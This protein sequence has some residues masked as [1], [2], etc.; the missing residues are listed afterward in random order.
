[1]A[2]QQV[3]VNLTVSDQSGSLK[4]RNKEAKEL[5]ENLSKAAQSAEKAIRQTAAAK[6]QPQGEGA[7]YGRARGIAGATGAGARDFA[8]QAQGLGGLVR[9]YATYAANVFAVS[10]AFR[11]L[12]DAM[13]TE[14]M[15]RGLDQLGARSG[16]ALGGLAKLFS[17]VTGGAISTRE[18][19]ESTA[20]AMS[21]GMSAKQFLQLGE[22]AR[23]ASQALGLSMPDAVNRLVR[24]T[25]KLEPELLDE[26]GL[27]TKVGKA[28]EDYARS[29]GKT[30][31]SLTDLEK[32]QAFLNAVIKEG[33]DKFAAI[34][35]PTNPYDKLLSSLK[36]VAQTILEVVN[37][38]LTPLVELLSKSPTAL[39]GVIAGLG[40]MILRQA[41]PIFTSYREAMAKANKEMELMAAKKAETAKKSLEIARRA[42]EQEVLEER[43]KLTEIR[44]D[45]ID[46]QVSAL[47]Q[48]SKRGISKG[49][50]KVID[51]L[52]DITKIT[53]QE[54]DMLDRLG[55]KN[56]KVAAVYKELAAAIRLA[57]KAEKD[58]SEQQAGID[59]RVRAPAPFL[60]RADIAE[61][62]LEKARRQAASASLLQRVGATAQEVGPMAA[63]GQLITGIKTEKLGLLRGGITAI[64]G[65]ASIATTAITGLFTAVSSFLGY[66]GI[67]TVIFET[68]DSLL[69]KNSK[70]AEAFSQALDMSAES[71]KSA[72][73]TA[74][75]FANVLNPQN[76][77]ASGNALINTKDS[78][79]ALTTALYNVDKA[80][81]GWD[82]FIDGFKAITGSNLQAKFAD[83]VAK[84]VSA[85]IAVI[86]DPKLQEE[87]K[88][89]LK[90]L[91]N[92]GEVTEESVGKAIKS[93]DVSEVIQT[94]RKVSTVFEVIGAKAKKA[95]NDIT[96]LQDSFTELD[97][98]FSELSNQLIAKD[99]FSTFGRN[100]AKTGFE[101]E[102]VFQNPTSAAANLLDIM[103]DMSKLKLLSPD[104]Q[105]MLLANK[106]AMVKLSDQLN[107]INTQ[108]KKTEDDL[109]KVASSGMD[110]ITPEG[111]LQ[112]TRDTTAE[113]KFNAQLAQLKGQQQT[114]QTAMSALTKD[115][116]G[117][118][119]QSIEYGFKIM[120]VSYERAVREGTIAAQKG[121]LDFLPKTPGTIQM[122]TKLE[123]DKISL[124]IQEINQTERLITEL[125][126]L[127]LTEER[128]RV[129]EET[130]R[131]LSSR[132]LTSAQVDLLLQ[133]KSQKIGAI[134]ARE[135]AL[136]SPNVAKAIKSGQIAL[137]S[138]T[139][140]VSDRQRASMLK[141]QG[142]LDQQQLNIIK[143]KVE[144]TAALADQDKRGLQL[145]KDSVLTDQKAFQQT[146]QYRAMSLEQQNAYNDSI[147]TAVDLLDKDLKLADNR[148]EV[149]VAETVLAAAKE[150]K[151]AEIIPTAQKEVDLAKDRLET[152][153]G[154]LDTTNQGNG[155]QRDRASFL[156]EISAQSREILANLDT[157]NSLRVIANA[158][159]KEQLDFEQRVL[160]RKLEQGK[161]TEGQ[162]IGEVTAIQ[163]RQ[164]EIDKNFAIEQAMNT[165]R[166]KVFELRDEYLKDESSTERALIQ[167]KLDGIALVLQ[168][169]ID[170]ANK[171]AIIAKADVDL[172][173]KRTQLEKDLGK[174]FESITDRMA[175]A[176]IKFA[177]TGKL[178]FKDMA[179]SII[180]DLV[181]IALKAQMVKLFEGQFGGG[182]SN[183]AGSWVAKFLGMGSGA[184]P[185]GPGAASDPTTFANVLAAGGLAKGGAF[186]SGVRKF[187]K[188][189]MFTNSIV[190][191]PTLFKFAKGAGMMGEA[192]PEAIM[193]LRRDSDGNL[194]VMAKPQGGNVEVVVNNYST[195]QAE[196]RETV[197]SRGNRKIEVIVGEMVA[198]EMGRK[199]SSVQQSMMNNFMAKP[200]MV[201]R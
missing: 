169:E 108:I 48:L 59:K 96:S 41:L 180:A 145:A 173:D 118:S 121:L 172:K 161:I 109:A 124:Q 148:K 93:L 159:L 33:T 12:S 92:V 9:L 71:A 36:N 192:G 7:E 160:D 50:Q 134:D 66:L 141:I 113:A 112:T 116:A 35:I 72:A 136:K 24:G 17:D 52:R 77:I 123:N 176:F 56:T 193:P 84:E 178:S 168:A 132:S 2:G 38:A 143:G 81:S 167:T 188:G 190:S 61:K 27:F 10:A 98:S 14:N 144:A 171:K 29:I 28:S 137:T 104:S 89:E 200:A 46:A 47:Q 32:R 166:Q 5:N 122:S 170:A 191:E 100:L 42:R 125:E 25:T 105:Q 83:S 110:I 37:K 91:F 138:E 95:G 86:A 75:A 62:E 175:D 181:K 4:E 149:A 20:K 142:L 13:N 152:E 135:A 51:P 198:G 80:S 195:A 151:F 162:Y 64:S 133:E 150:R 157:E 187:A 22:V 6:K 165:Y 94:G 45:Q 34:D 107:I 183:T 194:G 31:D 63:A 54:L 177:E 19:M 131:K 129:E 79:T 146:D 16:V 179:N 117:A 139:L 78:L 68:V 60:S 23:K 199:N 97:K 114:V 127:R 39:M 44:N 120:T 55:A 154:L 196:T 67:A 153:K 155:A 82:K 87:A 58:F 184:N 158:N 70:E 15:V 65:A 49:V 69:S 85:G 40:L 115:L 73:N 90:K 126:L 21:G 57:Q 163:Y 102:K 76:I 30:A 1:M 156:K 8:N 103:N 185:I 101:L 140:A 130:T 3:N 201:R 186:E 147:S 182:W 99:P 164:V 18:A 74:K 88:T 106:D 26:L 197:D 119:R 11:A 128:K 43:A 53:P 111:G 174:T 189:G